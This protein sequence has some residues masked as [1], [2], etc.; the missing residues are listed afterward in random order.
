MK[1]DVNSHLIRPM[2]RVVLSLIVVISASCAGTPSHIGASD[3]AKPLGELV[4]RGTVLSITGPTTDLFE[5]WII[6]MRVD[7][8]LFGSVEG[9]QFQFPVHSPAQSQLNVGE[10]Y[11]IR[12]TRTKT[13]YSVD[14]LQWLYAA[15]KKAR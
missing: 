10:Q 12:A 6:T 3:A 11:T 13:G 9:K 4:F 1:D 2:Q 5:P 8:V 7:K 15:A 14:E